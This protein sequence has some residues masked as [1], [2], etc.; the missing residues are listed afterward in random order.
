MKLIM[1]NW[2]KFLGKDSFINEG[3]GATLGRVKGKIQRT[4]GME[5]ISGRMTPYPDGKGNWINISVP[6]SDAD[7]ENISDDTLLFVAI[8]DK[9]AEE[10]NIKEPVITSGYRDAYR[11]ASAMYNVWLSS[12]EQGDTGYLERLYG[13]MCKS[14]SPGAGRVAAVIDNMFSTI[15]DPDEAKRAAGDLISTNLISK[16]NSVPGQAVDYRVGGHPDVERV[17]RTALKRGYVIGELI[18]EEKPPHWHM[19]VNSVT[20]DG[21]KYLQT[22]NVNRWAPARS[23]GPNWEG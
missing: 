10:L 1:E 3:L 14:C 8:I 19:T 2:R 7:V 12:K 16:H 13:T 23:P 5:T 11:Q 4:I 22:T 20:Q 17:F 6:Y 18:P 21:L 9:L 15:S